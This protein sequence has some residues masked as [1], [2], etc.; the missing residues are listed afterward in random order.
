MCFFVK[1]CFDW[2]KDMMCV[3]M[4]LTTKLM[5]KFTCF[6]YQILCLLFASFLIY[7]T[8]CHKQNYPHLS[9]ETLEAKKSCLRPT[10]AEEAR[11]RRQ[12]EAARK[13]GKRK[14]TNR[15]KWKMGIKVLKENQNSCDFLRK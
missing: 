8:K 10:C 11:A 2:D 3:R 5:R 12:N 13:K 1:K 6:S 14:E 4:R 7:E 9:E 15:G